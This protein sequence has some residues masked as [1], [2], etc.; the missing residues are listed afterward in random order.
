[1]MRNVRWSCHSCT[2]LQHLVCTNHQW[3]T[4]FKCGVK[5]CELWCSQIQKYVK[6]D[7]I[8][9]FFYDLPLGLQLQKISGHPPSVWFAL[10]NIVFQ[11]LIQLQT[12]MTTLIYFKKSFS[13]Q[14][15]SLSA[16]SVFNLSKMT[17]KWLFACTKIS[18][19]HL[20]ERSGLL[21]RC[22]ALEKL[23]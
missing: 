15:Y 5:E 13:L 19:R 1:M 9:F 22:F 23:T 6:R 2:V 14:T 20:A 12:L 3:S 7:L 18:L 17:F 11:C 21:Q 16:H 4:F 10:E 8:I